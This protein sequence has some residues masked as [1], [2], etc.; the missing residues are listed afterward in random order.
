M[1]VA[2]SQ[3]CVNGEIHDHDWI[4]LPYPRGECASSLNTAHHLLARSDIV[5]WFKRSSEL[6]FEE[7]DDEDV[8]PL[9]KALGYESDPTLTF[10]VTQCKNEIWYG[11]KKGMSTDAILEA[12]TDGK[13]GKAMPF[14]CDEDEEWFLVID[15]EDGEIKEWTEDD[16]MGDLL[17]KTFN[18]YLEEYRNGL[19]AGKFEFVEDCGCM[20]K[21]GGGGGDGDRK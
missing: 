5:A 1:S 17:G 12:I 9:A 6:E 3:Q 8:Q 16:G 2:E 19:L 10:L 13:F 15:G 21:A 14:A 4:C 11:D 20:E 7:G 18:D